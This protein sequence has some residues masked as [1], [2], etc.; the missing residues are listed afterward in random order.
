MNGEKWIDLRELPKYKDGRYKNK[1]NWKN[2]IGYKCKFKYYNIEGEIKIIYYNYP[3]IIIKYL[4][5]DLYTIGISDFIRCRLGKLLKKYTN[6]FK[7]QIG[8]TFKDYKRNLII[9]DR[10]YRIDKSNIKRK[11]YKYHCN[12]CG[13]EDWIEESGLLTNNGGCNVCC[14]PSKKVLQGY[15]DIYTTD[16]WMIELGVNIEDAKKY[17]SQSNKKIKVK[18]PHCK[19]EKEITINTIYVHKSIGCNCGDNISYPEKFVISL[20]DQ[21]NINYK[22]QY[23]KEWIKPK[24]YD[25]YF[26][27]DSKKYI[28][29]THGDFHYNEKGYTG[30]R[31]RT[32]QE[33]QENDKYKKELALKNGINYYIELDCRKSE[34]EYIKNSIINSELNKIFD[35]NKIDWLKCEEFALSNRVKEVCDYWHLHN[36]INNDGLLTTDLCEI[37]KLSCTTICKYLKQGTELGWCN[38]NPEEERK[39]ACLK[40]ININKRKIEIFKNGKSLGVFNSCRELSNKS[41]EL[42][43][44]K[45]NESNISSTATGR[46]KTHKGYTFKYI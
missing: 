23:S 25:F 7:V 41:E 9:V 13:N 44:I 27:L 20:L 17:T 39:K 26:E 37:F 4:D 2:S 16:Y 43:G 5:Y 19:K 45:L 35:L 24:R 10:E 11:Y 8:Q 28:I 29:E 12:K 32:L 34:L 42:F 36:E 33:E 14:T 21:L 40:A 22:T 15:N 1:I 3:K 38:Y 30:K 46:Q 31:I 6:E 18:C